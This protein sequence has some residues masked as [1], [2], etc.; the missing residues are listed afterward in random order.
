MLLSVCLSSSELWV[1]PLDCA[2]TR[3]DFPLNLE[4]GF[5]AT[6]PLSPGIALVMV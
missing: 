3:F 2:I 5:E 1:H 6:A 4:Q